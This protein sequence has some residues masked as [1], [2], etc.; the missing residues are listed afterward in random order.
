MAD[1]DTTGQ[2][3]KQTSAHQHLY[4]SWLSGFISGVNY[5]RDDR[6]DIAANRRVEDIFI[7]L[8]NYCTEQP[9]QDIPLAL[10]E[11]IQEWQDQQ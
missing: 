6:Y 11:L 3:R 2:S 5:A 1:L 8:Q 10:H 9:E 4:Q 7:W